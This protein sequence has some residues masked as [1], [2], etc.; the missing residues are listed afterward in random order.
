[1]KTSYQTKLAYEGEKIDRSSLQKVQ[2]CLSV[3]N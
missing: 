1:M 3:N 2:L